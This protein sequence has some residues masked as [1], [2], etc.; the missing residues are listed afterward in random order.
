METVKRKPRAHGA[1]VKGHSIPYGTLVGASAELHKAYYYHGY[2]EDWMLPEIPCPPY[3]DRECHSPEEELFKK[4]L[5]ERVEEVLDTLTPRAK[6]VVCLRY[7]I[8]LT[9]DYT[10]EEIGTR[11]DVTRERI[12]QIEA[13]AV[14]DLKH[15]ARAIK[16]REMLGQRLSSDKRAGKE[17]EAQAAQVQWAKE[18]NAAQQRDEARAQFK[19]TAKQREKQREQE[20]EEMYKEDL[21][22]REKW[23]EIKPMVSDVDWIEHLKVENPEMYQELRNVVTYIW[24]YNADKVWEM[25]AEKGERK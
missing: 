21:R 4:E 15:P 7:G 10:L 2:K 14:R 25:Y 11:F 3:E 20:L 16:L 19:V 13:K 6:K 5:V 9:H 23:E 18:R 24:G 17:L 12:R 1:I 8:G 22:L